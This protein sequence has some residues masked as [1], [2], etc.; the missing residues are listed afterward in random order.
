MA[1]DQREDDR[2]AGDQ[3]RFGAQKAR[4]APKTRGHLCAVRMAPLAFT[5]R[6]SHRTFLQTH[7]DGAS[8]LPGRLL[9][10]LLFWLLLTGERPGHR[11][12][13]VAYICGGI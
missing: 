7:Y 2:A 11:E 5:D 1:R 4:D 10:R 13:N 8:L 12:L 6:N 9:G 3:G